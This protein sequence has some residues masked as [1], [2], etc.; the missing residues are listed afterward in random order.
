MATIYLRQKNDPAA[1]QKLLE[2]ALTLMPDD[3]S[4]K[5]LLEQCKA[6]QKRNRAAK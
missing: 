3:P 4:C 6:A 5:A 1:A 2:E